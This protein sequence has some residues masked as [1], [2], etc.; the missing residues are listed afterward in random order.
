VEVPPERPVLIGRVFG[1]AA[2]S[3]I[4]KQAEAPKISVSGYNAL[5]AAN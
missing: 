2:E 5:V 3:P 1:L 4:A